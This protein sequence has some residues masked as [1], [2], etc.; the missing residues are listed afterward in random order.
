MP[1]VVFTGA[2]EVG[3]RKILRADL[4]RMAA[5]AGWAVCDKV[6]R[7]LTYLACSRTDTIKARDA[8]RMGVEC[9]TYPRL[10]FLLNGGNANSP[11]T[12]TNVTQL[13]RFNADGTPRRPAER[14]APFPPG[15][16]RRDIIND[17][18]RRRVDEHRA[19]EQLAREAA[20]AARPTCPD[21]WTFLRSDGSCH[22]CE[23]GRP[24]H[25]KALED[26]RA[27]RALDLGPEP[28]RVT[29]HRS[30]NLGD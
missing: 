13:D 26:Q 12:I 24:A 5:R 16:S 23:A 1:S 3:G 4:A 27:K 21:H 2:A 7:G 29:Q 25:D 11:A 15:T 14:T 8:S 28:E 30:I 9:I 20:A 22:E 6:H 10:M 18:E 17:E 19:R